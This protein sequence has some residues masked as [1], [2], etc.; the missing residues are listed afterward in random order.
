MFQRLSFLLLAWFFFFT[1]RTNDCPR[2]HCGYASFQPLAHLIAPYEERPCRCKWRDWFAARR[3][4][5]RGYGERP[6][7]PL[8]ISLWTLSELSGGSF[9]VPMYSFSTACP[10]RSREG[11]G[12]HRVECPQGLNY[13]ERFRE[14][15][16]NSGNIFSA[17]PG[18]ID[19]VE[20]RQS[21]VFLQ[22]IG[23]K[24][25]QLRQQLLI[26]HCTKRIGL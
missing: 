1:H 15:L 19:S 7:W 23:S 14:S 13:F 20:I 21:W 18:A 4:A 12:Q 22:T 8:P 2:F 26:V 9:C 24:S 17:D 5:N 16:C 6:P 10:F 3:R 25:K 11:G